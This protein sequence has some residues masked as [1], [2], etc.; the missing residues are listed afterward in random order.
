MRLKIEPAALELLAV[1]PPPV[2]KCLRH[3][4]GEIQ[5]GSLRLIASGWRQGLFYAFACDHIISVA[6]SRDG[7]VVFVLGLYSDPA[8]EAL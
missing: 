2:R 4:L 6:Y 1:S 7:E 8:G 3:A 5:D